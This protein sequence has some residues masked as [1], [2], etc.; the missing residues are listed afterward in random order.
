MRCLSCQED[1]VESGDRFCRHCGWPQWQECPGCGAELGLLEQATLC[2]QCNAFLRPCPRSGCGRALTYEA[3]ACS[4]LKRVP[5]PALPY[6]WLSLRGDAGYNRTA[7]FH[8]LPG[9]QLPNQE[10]CEVPGRCREAFDSGGVGLLTDSHLLA[11]GKIAPVVVRPTGSGSAVWRSD[12]VLVQTREGVFSEHNGEWSSSEPSAR[13]WWPLAKDAAAW[14]DEARPDVVWFSSNDSVVGERPIREVLADERFAVV[15]GD[16]GL[17]VLDR[18]DWGKRFSCEC[19]GRVFVMSDGTLWWDEDGRLKSLDL[20]DSQGRQTARFPGAVASLAVEGGRPVIAAGD[21]VSE[22]VPK[23][24]QWRVHRSFPGCQVDRLVLAGSASD[25]R[26]LVQVRHD[27]YTQLVEI[28]V[29]DNGDS[30]THTLLERPVDC[31]LI[32]FFASSGMVWVVSSKDT[33]VVLRP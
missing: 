27:T 28:V 31:D 33:T 15:I 7:V 26:I 21:C 18:A 2:R 13:R 8:W 23:E 1:G 10:I 11:R 6:R 22:W 32:P 17:A 20:A 16:R 12:G 14:V 9:S 3:T 5:A 29:G 19:N 4:C 24:S 30:V 25:R